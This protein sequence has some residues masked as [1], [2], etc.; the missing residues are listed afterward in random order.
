MGAR[1]ANE[2]SETRIVTAERSEG[3]RS[4]VDVEFTTRRHLKRHSAASD[5]ASEAQ[6]SVAYSVIIVIGREQQQEQPVVR[7]LDSR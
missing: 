5:N 6:R 2:Q 1:S 3:L 4:S 7:E